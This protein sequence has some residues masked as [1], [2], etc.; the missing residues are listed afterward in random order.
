[1]SNKSVF[2]VTSGCYSDYH[3]V[4]I[5]DTREKADQLVKT[6]DDGNVEEHVL[7][8]FI[9]EINKGLSIFTVEMKANGDTIRV[10]RERCAPGDWDYSYK[11]TATIEPICCWKE[12]NNAETIFGKQVF[13]RDEKHAVKIVNELRAQKLATGR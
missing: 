10:E 9:T 1:M 5:Y 13:A 3:I 11:L 2:V 6:L 4:G 7:N 12:R 8:P